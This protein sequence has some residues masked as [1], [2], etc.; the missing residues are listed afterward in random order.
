MAVFLPPRAT[1]PLLERLQADPTRYV[2]RSLANH[3]NDITKS[4][5]DW[6]VQTLAGWRGPDLDYIRRHALRCLGK[7]CHP[8]A[9]KLLGYH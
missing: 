1:R 6:V 2:T 7:R 8:G 3:L 9:L 4:E 5:P